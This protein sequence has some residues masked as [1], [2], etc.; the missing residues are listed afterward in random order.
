MM[1]ELEM[2]SWIEIL[3]Q[4]IAKLH[5]ETYY[6]LQRSQADQVAVERAQ[7]E[8]AARLASERAARESERAAWQSERT[9]LL[10]EKEQLAAEEEKELG[11]VGEMMQSALELQMEA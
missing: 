1:R 10:A 8:S 3:I 5:R 6:T 9:T 7:E 11:E 2:E 4:E